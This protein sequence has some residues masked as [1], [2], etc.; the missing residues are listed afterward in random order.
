MIYFCSAESKPFMPQYP[1]IFYRNP[2]LDT[3]Q[4]ADTVCVVDSLSYNNVVPSFITSGFHGTL[5]PMPRMTY[6]LV[7]GWN[8][9]VLGL[10]LLLI[11][12]NRQLFPRQF[13]QILSISG[14]V[15]RTN[16]VLREWSPTRSFLCTTF[17]I[18][19]VVLLA[20]FVQKSC[21]IL[22][23]D[24]MQYNTVQVFGIVCAAVAGWVLLRYFAL[25]LVNWLFDARDTVDRQMT[26]QFSVSILTLIAMIPMLLLL[27]YN[28]SSLFVWVG[29]GILGVAAIMRF[30]IGMIETRVSTKLPA[31]YIFLYF[32][33]LEIAPIATLVTASLRYFSHSTVL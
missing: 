23:R 16:Q 8:L 6:D 7:Q 13:R 1:D 25:Y 12:V 5:T 20:L 4:A 18:G 10:M 11:V 24:V 31:F 14:G 26:V 3:S 29:I 21:V 28:P 32:C 15:A 27:L 33:A 22:S 2:I 9:A 17:T 19:Y 30:V